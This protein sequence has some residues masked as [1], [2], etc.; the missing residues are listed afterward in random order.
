MINFEDLETKFLSNFQGG[1]GDILAKILADDTHRIIKST[2]APGVSTG[3]HLHDV[4]DEII[5]I[6][7]GSCKVFHND[8]EER[9]LPGD[10][11][12]CKL[13]ESHAVVNDGDTDLVM[14]AVVT[15]L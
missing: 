4:S 7:E 10:C 15:N 14:F 3:Y 9:L 13:G 6:L 1:Q 11:H 5:Y 2:Y 12:Y 8:E